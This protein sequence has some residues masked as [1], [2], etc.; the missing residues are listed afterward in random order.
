MTLD[1]VLTKQRNQYLE[2]YKMGWAQKKTEKSAIEVMLQTTADQNRHLPEIYQLYRFDLINVNAEGKYDLTEF[3]LDKDSLLRYDKHVFDFDGMKVEIQPFIWN[4][5]EF[6]LDQKPDII[7]E[8][9]SRKWLDIGDTKKESSDGF[10]EVI[11]NVT[12]PNQNNSEWTTSI[13]FGSAPIEAFKEL[14][15]IWR[16]QGIKKV[17]VHSNSFTGSD[18]R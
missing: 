13:D 14:L 12:Y 5:C 6:T 9:W 7:F 2:S 3:N 4:A 11:H 16:R 10:L 17:K 1:E 15:E 8:N 18:E